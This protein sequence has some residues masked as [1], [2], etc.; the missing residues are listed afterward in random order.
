VQ[1]LPGVSRVGYDSGEGLFT[2]DYDPGRT[3][4]A[5]IFAA[6]FVAGKKMGQEYLPRLVS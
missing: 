4:A 1:E 6:V 5:A 3:D 2:A